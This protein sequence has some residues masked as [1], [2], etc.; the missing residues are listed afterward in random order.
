MTQAVRE[1]AAP[2]NSPDAGHSDQRRLL[3]EATDR[4]GDREGHCRITTRRI[5]DG[6]AP[7]PCAQTCHVR[8]TLTGTRLGRPCVG[9]IPGASGRGNARGTIAWAIAGLVGEDPVGN[10]RGRRCHVHDENRITTGL[11]TDRYRPLA[12]T[13]TADRGA[14]AAGRRRC[15][16]PCS[17][18]WPPRPGLRRA[19]AC[20]PSGAA[21]CT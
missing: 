17:F 4:I 5:R 21:R 11:V 19:N 18:V 6:H 7:V 1:T 16:V 3:S 15:L 20:R 14:T 13:Q 2:V 12:G 10:E 9:E 8:R